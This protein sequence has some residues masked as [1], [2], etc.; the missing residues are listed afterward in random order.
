MIYCNVRIRIVYYCYVC[1]NAFVVVHS[2]VGGGSGG[3]VDDDDDA[4]V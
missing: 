3:G 2:G 4:H 1:S